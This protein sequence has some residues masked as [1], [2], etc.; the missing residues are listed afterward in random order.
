M[1]AASVAVALALGTLTVPAGAGSAGDLKDR[2]RAVQ[3]AIKGAKSDVEVSS[4]RLRKASGR[5]ARAKTRLDAAKTELATARG[6]LEVATERDRVMQA[7]LADAEA[8]LA[9]AEA[10]LAVGQDDRDSQRQVVA[11]TISDI[12]MEGD[13]ELLAF[14]SLMEADDTEDLTRRNEVRDLVVGRESKEYDQLKAA[15]VLLSVREAEVEKS[16]DAVAVKREEARQHVE[17]MAGIEAEK[18]AAK[19]SVVMLVGERAKARV[20]ARK[21]RARDLATLRKHQKQ[22]AQIKEKLRQLALAAKRRAERR[23]RREARRQRQAAQAQGQSPS[24][25]QPATGGDSGGVLAQPTNTYVTSSFG[26]R[27]HPIYGYWGLHDGTD[28]GGGCGVPLL[29]AA[30]GKVIASYWSDVYGHRLV[31]DHGYQAGVGLATIYNHASSYSVGVGDR[32]T[33]G[34]TIGSMGD[35]GWSTA[36]H[37]HFTVMAN[38]SA[39]DP[40]KWF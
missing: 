14:S 30:D 28:F 13:P 33:R 11:D 26:Y 23:A 6:R 36:C 8:E 18:Q 3:K 21:A 10:D 16:R 35:T 1:A 9:Q 37:L 20:E 12:Y 29:A 17:L 34:Q 25:S 4:D 31:I 38:G 7:E 22:E 24:P 19:S 15:E 27:T 5:L 2:E 39:V 32:V 40:M